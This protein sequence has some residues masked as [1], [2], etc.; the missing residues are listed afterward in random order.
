VCRCRR[1]GGLDFPSEA[2]VSPDGTRL[3]VTNV[4]PG[5]V[6][7]FDTVTFQQIDGD[8]DPDPGVIGPIAVGFLPRGVAVTPDGHWV[9]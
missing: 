2:A 9:Y 1:I 4:V 3:Y 8:L 6:S 5:T 7:V